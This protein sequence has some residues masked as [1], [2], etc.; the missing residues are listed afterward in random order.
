MK[1]GGG[2]EVDLDHLP[3][4]SADARNIV[5]VGKRLT[6]VVRREPKGR[7]LVRIEPGAKR[8]ILA[9]LDLSGLDSGDRLD[10]RLDDA[11]QIVGDLVG[12]DDVAVEADIHR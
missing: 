8:K 1:A 3:F 2:L 9:A 12:R 4:G 7:Q 10:L 6:D 11:N 5:V